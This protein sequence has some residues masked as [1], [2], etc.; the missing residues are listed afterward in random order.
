MWLDTRLVGQLRGWLPS[1]QQ[2]LLNRSCCH[3]CCHQPQFA[4]HALGRRLGVS[5]A[6]G[7]ECGLRRS[8]L[9]WLL[10]RLDAWLVRYLDCWL[11]G[12][13]DGLLVRRLGR[14]RDAGLD[15]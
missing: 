12:C 1:L 4:D 13:L 2:S 15:R 3:R 9:C 11:D 7:H 14:W 5:S 10:G 8:L 6:L